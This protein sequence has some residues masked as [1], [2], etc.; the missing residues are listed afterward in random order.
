MLKD[1]ELFEV[2]GVVKS[3]FAL[4]N[5]LA[6]KMLA[7]LVRAEMILLAL[8]DQGEHPEIRSHF[9]WTEG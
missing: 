2:R 3:G 8:L 9:Q 5:S 7:R 1:S 4:D 6:A